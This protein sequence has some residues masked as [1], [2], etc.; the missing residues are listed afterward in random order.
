MG[1]AGRSQGPMSLLEE[2]ICTF[3][4][5][6]DGVRQIPPPSSL[7]SY[8]LEGK[9]SVSIICVLFPFHPQEGSTELR[10]QRRK[11]REGWHYGRGTRKRQY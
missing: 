5:E 2:V 4:L 7:P 3:F 8:L 1:K 10:P 9:C 11:C 6:R